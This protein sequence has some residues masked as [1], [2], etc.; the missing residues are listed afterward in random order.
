MA[1]IAARDTDVEPRSISARVLAPLALIACLLA[2]FLLVS[3]TLSGGDDDGD[4]RP[5]SRQ[6]RSREEPT[7]KGD[8]YIVV[9]GDTFTG[10]RGEDGDPAREARAAQPGHRSRH[11]ERGPNDQ[12]SLSRALAA[13]AAACL[14]LAVGP[15]AAVAAPSAPEGLPASSWLLVE[16]ESGDVLAAHDAGT[17]F[18]I[19]SATKLMTAYLTFKRLEPRDKVTAPAYAAAATESLM[20]LEPGETVSV[21]DLLYGL[22]LESGNDAA[23]ALALRV[24]GSEADFVA[25]M[26]ASAQRLG[27]D[28]TAYADPIG[29]D[30][31]QRLERPRPRRPGDQ[32]APRG[33]VPPDRRH[34]ADHRR[35]GRHPAPAREPQHARAR[36]AFRRRDQD[37]HDARRRLRPGGV[38]RAPRRRARVRAAGRPER[39]GSQRRDARAARVR[40]L[41]LPAAGAG[42][43]R[44]ADRVDPAR[45]RSRAPAARGRRHGDRGGAG[46]PARRG[47]VRRPRGP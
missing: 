21:R 46:R 45:R 29:L 16:E 17:A 19:A 27:L 28:D 13:L 12:A 2:L 44:R 36:G 20:G 8:A 4:R 31:G 30:V 26:N 32:A 47:G 39:G 22:L 9:P 10:D 43:A 37:R 7:V 38:G 41:A 18:P 15:A 11:P 14:A 35:L 34:A 25:L 5:V 23:A 1:T 3:E 42:R 40:D 6:E 33:A 24:S